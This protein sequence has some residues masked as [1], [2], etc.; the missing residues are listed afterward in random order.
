MEKTKLHQ[1]SLKTLVIIQEGYSSY[2]CPEEKKSQNFG[3][4]IS[5][6]FSVLYFY[7]ELHVN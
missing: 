1:K 7:F 2:S 6:Y 3:G 4:F 5:T